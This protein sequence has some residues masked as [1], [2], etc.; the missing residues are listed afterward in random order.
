[1]S[2]TLQRSSEYRCTRSTNMKCPNCTAENSN[3]TQF[4][5][6]CGRRMNGG[7][8]RLK[9]ATGAAVMI[10]IAALVIAFA[11]PGSPST[12]GSSDTSPCASPTDPRIT[13]GI[14]YGT[15]KQDW[16]EAAARSFEQTE[17]GSRIHIEL[18]PLGSLDAA[19]AIVRNDNSIHVWSPASALYK[20]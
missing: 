17:A 4:C 16:F 11:R 10:A 5:R 6:A 12:T 20:E 14:A 13:L 7:T 3:E 8:S 2:R 1:S 19:H 18:K 9:F 15:E